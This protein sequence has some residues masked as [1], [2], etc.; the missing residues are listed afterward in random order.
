[1][2][3]FQ[4]FNG[5]LEEE[6]EIREKI[7]EIQRSLDSESK[8]ATNILQSIHTD[9]AGVGKVCMEA[10]AVFEKCREL[11]QQIAVLIPVG[12]YYRFNDHWSWITSRLVSLIAI[13][14]YLEAG[15]LVSRDTSAEIL[16]C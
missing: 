1:M 12:Q 16:G 15:F 2:D 9:L 10:R 4:K 5:H 7:R 3:M 8:V 14:V 11:Y 13:V 6:N